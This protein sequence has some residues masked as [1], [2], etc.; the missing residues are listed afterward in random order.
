MQG[1]LTYVRE[2]LIKFGDA[3]KTKPEKILPFISISQAFLETLEA[4]SD[5]LIAL[6][7]VDRN[8]VTE[9]QVSL[10]QFLFPQLLQ[11]VE[12][13]LKPDDIG[14]RKDGSLAA[15]LI[16]EALEPLHIQSCHVMHYVHVIED[17]MGKLGDRDPEITGIRRILQNFLDKHAAGDSLSIRD[18]ALDVSS[19]AGRLDVQKQIESMTSKMD[20]SEKLN[21][22]Q[23]LFG[24]DQTGLTQLNKLLAIKHVIASCESKLAPFLYHLVAI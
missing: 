11:S 2:K 13:K 23:Q 5:Q 20:N 22:L 3:K 7:I 6:N 14:T 1:G 24:E 4:K 16:L 10:R 17:Y 19:H 8:D 15:L 18:D 12:K 21:L 9:L